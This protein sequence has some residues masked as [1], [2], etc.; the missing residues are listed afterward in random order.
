MMPYMYS[1]A[2]WTHFKDYTIMRGLVMDFNGDE[3][4]YDVKDQWMF[5]PAMMACPVGYYQRYTRDVYLPKQCGWYDLYTGAFYIRSHT[6][7]RT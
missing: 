2:G 6:G 7:V 4:V 5:G 3:N 1:L